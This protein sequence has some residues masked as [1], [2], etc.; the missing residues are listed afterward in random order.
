MTAG[1]AA[2][3]QV[4]REMI[5]AGETIEKTQQVAIYVLRA[6]NAGMPIPNA[7]EEALRALLFGPFPPKN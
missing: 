2:A 4:S 7:K 6:V 1:E 5:A 3:R